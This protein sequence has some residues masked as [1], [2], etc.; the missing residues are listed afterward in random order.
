[1][2]AI[3]VTEPNYEHTSTRASVRGLEA[4][5]MQT[6]DCTV[7]DRSFSASMHLNS[8]AIHAVA[9]KKKKDQNS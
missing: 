7:E 9:C 1:M 5:M 8:E 3:E 2:Q 6:Y 4:P